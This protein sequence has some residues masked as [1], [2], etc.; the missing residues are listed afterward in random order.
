[1]D[2]F[3]AAK[4][5][6]AVE[7]LHRYTSL[8]TTRR[9]RNEWACCPFHSEKTPSCAFDIS[10][11]GEW[12]C[13]GCHAGGT[14][15][16]FVARY[17]DLSTRDAAMK[18]CADYGLQTDDDRPMTR[19]AMRDMEAAKKA[20]EAQERE[21]A[22]L[23]LARI[24]FET[25][26]CVALRRLKEYRDKLEPKERDSDEGLSKEFCNVLKQLSVLEEVDR[27]L[28]DI[29]QRGDDPQE[30]RELMDAYRPMMKTWEAIGRAK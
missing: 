6:P 2:K 1:M 19:E 8:K 5:I 24:H 4:T 9:G 16:D 7:V 28:M 23:E 11:K 20:R 29:M 12:Y 27:R 3:E 13:L 22:E 14:S 10:G 18:I 21:A 30:L 17:F 25:V 15:I 26:V